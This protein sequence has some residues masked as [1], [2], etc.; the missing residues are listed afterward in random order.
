MYAQLISSQ[1][2]TCLCPCTFHLQP[3]TCS[4]I[5]CCACWQ[6]THCHISVPLLALQ[7]F[8]KVRCVYP[9]L[10][11]DL[12]GTSMH[13]YHG[14]LLLSHTNA[15]P[16]YRLLFQIKMANEMMLAHKKPV[17]CCTCTQYDGNI[18][19]YMSCALKLV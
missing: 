16:L 3:L 6:L 15:V 5:H 17:N 8:D 14:N 4:N 12:H 18:Y 13:F 19:S 1:S 7:L 11:V 10:P 9:L 2:S